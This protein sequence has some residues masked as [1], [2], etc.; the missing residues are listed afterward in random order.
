MSSPLRRKAS[1]TPDGDVDVTFVSAVPAFPSLLTSTSVAVEIDISSESDSDPTVGPFVLTVPAPVVTIALADES[2]DGGADSQSSS[3]SS[4]SDVVVAAVENDEASAATAAAA[5]LRPDGPGPAAD[6]GATRDGAD[7]GDDEARSAGTVADG[8][9]AA[10][11]PPSQKTE[12]AT[13][14]V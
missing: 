13:T 3:S 1:R 10:G 11:P 5:H 6:G 4:D 8:D 7:R 9:A 2:D 14:Q 12:A